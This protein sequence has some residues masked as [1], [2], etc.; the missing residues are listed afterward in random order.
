MVLAVGTTTSGL[1]M[2]S[3]PVSR[4]R[5]ATPIVPVKSSAS[6]RMRSIVSLGSVAIPFS[7]LCSR[8]VRID[9][10]QHNSMTVR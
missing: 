4:S 6:A 1:Y 2:T 10:P 3:V 7:S 9:S 8:C 5:A